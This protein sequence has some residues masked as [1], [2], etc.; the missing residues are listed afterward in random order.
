MAAT[1]LPFL[2]A[3][4]L[5]GPGRSCRGRLA[6]ARLKK[7]SHFSLRGKKQGGTDLIWCLR[8]VR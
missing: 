3:G 5:K 6:A 2:A 4:N 7:S 1:G 8:Q